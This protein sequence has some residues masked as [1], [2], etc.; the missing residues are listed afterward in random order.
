LVIA[1]ATTVTLAVP[2]VAPVSEAVIVPLPT[3][4]PVN[5]VDAPVAGLTVPSPL[6]GNQLT[7]E[8]L[9]PAF[10]Y[11]SV[12]VTVNFWLAPTGTVALA[13]ETVSLAAGPATIDHVNVVL[14]EPVELV[15]VTVTVDLLVVVAA[16]PA[17]SPLELI[18][19]PEGSP[20]A[21]KVHVVQL[22]P[23][24]LRAFICRLADV[25]TVV[26]RLPG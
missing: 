10:P 3:A 25:P 2:E 26:V 23:F 22:V 18:E 20:V 8:T 5:V 17:I 15:A 16:V 11:W 4:P 19:N 6:G 24:A 14:P 13:G 12:P 7:C 21:V 1:L 9:A